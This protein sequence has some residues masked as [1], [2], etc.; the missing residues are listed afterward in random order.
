MKAY[1]APLVGCSIVKVDVSGGFPVIVARRR[2]GETF[3]LEVS[4]DEE[5]NGPGF[6]FG[7][8]YPSDRAVAKADK[9]RQEVIDYLKHRVGDVGAIQVAREVHQQKG[10][11]AYF[12]GEGFRTLCP[13][14][15]FQA[16]ADGKA[17]PSDY[18]PQAEGADV[19][20]LTCH[21]CGLTFAERRK[22]LG[23]KPRKTG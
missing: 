23:A 9:A 18:Q 5:G 1:L 11:V 16:V 13:V 2:N 14:C 21:E 22:R 19:G 4:R 8:P 10:T 17:D 15:Y 6:L 12:H 3:T 7:L 20:D